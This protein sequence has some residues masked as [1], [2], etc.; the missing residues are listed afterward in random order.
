[1]RRIISTAL[2]CLAAVALAGCAG[3]PK[4][5]KLADASGQ[6]REIVY[7][8]GTLFGGISKDQAAATAQIM[9]ESHNLA[10]NE[11][12]EIRG[13]SGRIERTSQK[14][15]SSA[16]RMEDGLK[17]LD[18]STQRIDE[19]TASIA[20]GT[21]KIDEGVRKLADSNSRIESASGR[22]EGA[23]QKLMESA[24]KSQETSQAIIEAIEKLAK[25]QGTGEVTIF[26]PVGSDLIAKNSLEYQ[27]VV[28]FADYLARESHGR[29]VLFL[30]VGSAS[31]FG[32][33]DFNAKLAKNRAEA[34]MAV[35][36]KYMVN[37]P[38][39]F[40]KVYGTGDLYSPKDVSMEEH[41][42]YQHTRLIAVFE[43]NQVPLTPEKPPEPLARN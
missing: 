16:A 15:E 31:A 21:Q 9:V 42:K 4:T 12:G 41:Q 30:S 1:M 37:T 25:R 14:I 28:N 18:G 29:K 38:H 6:T 27:R 23:T 17:K 13:T 3:Q 36:D 39:E 20:G 22:I 19:R 11:M 24:S 40:F 33:R 8:K 2:V 32:D 7:P 5:L 43:T 10:M 34:P 35:L 26:F